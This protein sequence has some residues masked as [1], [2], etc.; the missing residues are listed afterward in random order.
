M[1]PR[2]AGLQALLAPFDGLGELGDLDVIE[3]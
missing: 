2:I 1:K 3:V